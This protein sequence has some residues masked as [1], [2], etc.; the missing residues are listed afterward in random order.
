V[1]IETRIVIVNDDFTRQLGAVLGVTQTASVGNNGL[2]ETTGTAAGTDLGLSS[3][4]SNLATTG[5]VYPVGVPTGSTAANRYNVNLPVSSPAGSIAFMLLGNSN[6]VDLEL[7][8]AQA[9]SRGEIVSSPRV[10]TANQQEATIKQGVEIPYQQ[11]A[12]SGATTISFK[13]AV[14]LLKVKPLITPDNRIILDLD[15][16]DDAVGSVV[17]ASGGVNVPAID[18]RAIKT[19]VLVGDGQTVVLGGILSTTHTDDETKVPWLGDIPILGNLFKT[20]TKTNNKDE[21]LIF[22]TPKIIR[23]GVSVN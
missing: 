15:I 7:S 1:L 10:I 6:I 11:S 13:D 20:T 9:E 23:E 4:L 12:S 3:A 17:V 18:T 14:L 16:S 5:S 8:A 21:L 2:F 19:T 22:V